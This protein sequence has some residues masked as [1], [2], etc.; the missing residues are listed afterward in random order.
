MESALRQ[1][2]ARVAETTNTEF[3]LDADLRNELDVDSH[4]AVEL[5]FEIERHFGLSI[6]V[7]RLDELRTLRTSV[8]LITSLKAGAA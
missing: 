8:A 6:P 7:D 2:I 5:V 1:I 4:R 3:S